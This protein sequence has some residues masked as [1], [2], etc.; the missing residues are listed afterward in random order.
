MAMRDQL[1]HV[2]ALAATRKITRT[3]AS[4]PPVVADITVA[5]DSSISDKLILAQIRQAT[6][7]PLDRDALEE[8][9]A[10]VY[11]YDYFESVNYR[12]LPGEGET[13]LSIDVREKS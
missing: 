3:A 6:G 12:L 11:G 4:Q 10:S 8:D 9:L 7:A 1:T 5:N 2:A 13:T